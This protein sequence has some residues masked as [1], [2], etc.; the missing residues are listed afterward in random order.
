MSAQPKK[1]LVAFDGTAPA[2]RALD[3]AAQL[4]GYGSTLT[5]VRVS[6]E[7]NHRG[8]D[9]LADARNLLHRRQ[10]TARYVE[11][12]GEPATELV[13]AARELEVDLVV[14]AGSEPDAVESVASE[15]LRLA[16]TNV[17]V[18]R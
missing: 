16:K 5:V 12:T 14:V 15:V 2:V 9:V 18:V 7:G 4:V 11:R 17:L 10:V 3:A 6:P 8:R 1:I 13:A